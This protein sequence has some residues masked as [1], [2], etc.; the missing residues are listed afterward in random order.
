MRRHVLTLV[1]YFVGLSEQ[2]LEGV[3]SAFN[4]RHMLKGT[5]LVAAGD[6]AETLFVIVSGRVKLVANDAEGNDHVLDV[7]GPGDSF[8]ALPILGQASN[9]HRVEALTGGCVLV[10]STAEFGDLV[11]SF[12]SVAVAVLEDVS[13]RLREAQGRLQA[14]TSSSVE[15]RLAATLLT[16]SARFGTDTPDGRTLGV[17][18]S[19]EELAALVGSTL[20]SVN[21]VLASWRRGGLVITGRLKV[22]LARPDELAH[23]AGRS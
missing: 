23:I 5:T 4:A 21:R 8:G 7:R 16:L 9:E 12:P 17:P 6:P 18:L 11:T 10:T 20:E 1:P 15:A 14:A 3:H 19:Q 22:T 13:R 2:D